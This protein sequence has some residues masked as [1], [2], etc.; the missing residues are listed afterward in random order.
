[1]GVA[2]ANAPPHR[3][4]TIGQGRI[5]RQTK[6][7]AVVAAPSAGFELPKLV[8]ALTGRLPPA[9]PVTASS[10]PIVAPNSSGRWRRE[11]RDE[12]V[13]TDMALH[14]TTLCRGSN[15]VRRSARAA[16]TSEWGLRSVSKTP[17]LCFVSIGPRK[18]ATGA[19][20]SD[21]ASTVVE[22]EEQHA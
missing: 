16:S 9:R 1:M 13:Q 12:A 5:E 20:T 11:R 17:T 4:T 10:S 7:L 21:R 15:V 18:T 19:D 22:M 3:D 6:C 2:G 8:C 14:P